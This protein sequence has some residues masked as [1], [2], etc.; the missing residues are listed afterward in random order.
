MDHRVPDAMDILQIMTRCRIGT[1]CPRYVARYD[2]GVRRYAEA[3]IAP[4]RLT[5]QRVPR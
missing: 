3:T 5:P 4:G 1:G 2:S